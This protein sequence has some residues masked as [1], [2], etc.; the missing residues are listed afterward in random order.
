MGGCVKAVAVRDPASER[1]PFNCND[2]ST[3]IWHERAALCADVLASLDCRQDRE[4]SIA[5]VGCGDKKLQQALHRKGFTCRYQGYD[6]L[7]Q[8]REV[9]RFDVQTETLPS[10]Y[11]VVV[12]LGVVEYLE[13]PE[14]VFASLAQQA[15]WLLLSHVI[16]QGDYYTDARRAE[17]GWRNHFTT[18]EIT[19]M[20]KRSGLSVVRGEMTSDNRTLLMACR[21]LRFKPA[22][23]AA[24]S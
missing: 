16:R 2:Q 3:A 15:P 9:L 7:P 14:R 19:G 24:R 23:A 6:I 13:H 18:E 17:L 20:L 22:T 8:T 1:M 10:T 12:L 5:D 4:L 11:D 21:S